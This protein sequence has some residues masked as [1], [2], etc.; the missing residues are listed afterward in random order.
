MEQLGFGKEHKIPKWIHLSEKRF[1]KY[2]RGETYQGVPFNIFI[3]FVGKKYKYFVVYGDLISQ[4]ESPIVTYYRKRKY[5]I[6]KRII[7]V[8]QGKKVY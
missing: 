6:L 8:I 1:R 3:S 5:G 4:G 7:M 2:Y